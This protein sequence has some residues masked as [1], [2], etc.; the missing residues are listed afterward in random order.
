MWIRPGSRS[1]CAV[2]EHRGTSPSNPVLGALVADGQWQLATG[3]SLARLCTPHVAKSGL[4]FSW[5]VA[6]NG[7]SD[8]LTGEEPFSFAWSLPRLCTDPR[9]GIRLRVAVNLA[10]QPAVRLLPRATVR[11]AVRPST[12]RLRHHQWK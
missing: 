7:S 9:V 11:S 2:D 8:S 5:T 4:K 12:R 6:G 3:N 1:V 10:E